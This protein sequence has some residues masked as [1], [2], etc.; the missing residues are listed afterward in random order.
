[1]RRDS[2]ITS[3]LRREHY[4]MKLPIYLIDEVIMVRSVERLSGL[5]S[6]PRN[7]AS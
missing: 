7:T 4:I 3:F 6:E 2:Y 1:M 5:H